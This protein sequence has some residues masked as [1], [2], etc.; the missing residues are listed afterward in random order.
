M[1]GKGEISALITLLDDPDES[2][3]KHVEGKL[4]SF[5][6]EVIPELESAWEHTFDAI[7]QKRIENLIHRIQFENVGEKLKNWQ[8]NSEHDLLEGLLIVAKYQ[9]PDLNDLKVKTQIERIKQDIWLEMRNDLTA[10]EKV[11]IIN[12]ILFDV[13]GFSGNTS[14]YHAPQNSFINIVLESKKG[15][16][17][18]LSCL[19]QIIAEELKIPIYGINLPEHFVL[20]YV[21]EHAVFSSSENTNGANILFYINAFSKGTPFGVKEIDHFLRQLKLDPIPSYYE[22]C[23]NSDIIRRFLRNLSNSFEKLGDI[24]KKEEMERLLETLN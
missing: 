22:P 5:G 15:N 16:P 17:I 6:S 11:K 9:Y 13:H 10:Q 3:F 18:S 24:D 21:D 8:K 7:H 20:G 12:H 1:T 4:I 14:N 19:Y 2:I 23:S